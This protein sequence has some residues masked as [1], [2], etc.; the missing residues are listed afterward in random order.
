[1]VVHWIPFD[2]VQTK[3]KKN[4]FFYDEKKELFKTLS[5][6][7]LLNPSKKFKKGYPVN[8]ETAVKQNCIDEKWPTLIIFNLWLCIESPLMKNKQSTKKV[9]FFYDK[10][11]KQLLKEIFI[12]QHQREGRDHCLPFNLSSVNWKT[13]GQ[14]MI[15][16]AETKKSRFWGKIVKSRIF[17]LKV[18]SRF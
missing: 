18:Q 4:I 1:M 10:Q 9:F 17:V 2:E 5:N 8:L 11:K 12:T 16:Y 3:H 6:S 13:G 7:N 14:N 15:V